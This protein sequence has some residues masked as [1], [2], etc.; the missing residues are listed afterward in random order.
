MS[1]KP[2]YRVANLEASKILSDSKDIQNFPFNVSEVIRDYTDLK[3]ATYSQALK[4]EIDIT[5]RSDEAF[6]IEMNGKYIL[7]V[8]EKKP[9]VNQK[10]SLAH[11]L[12]HFILGHEVDSCK[13]QREETEANIF[14]AQLL[15]PEHIIYELENRG[16]NITP[17]VLMACF[18]IS[19]TAADIR[20]ETLDKI[21]NF[22]KTGEEKEIN[23]G[24]VH[25]FYDFII[26]AF[27]RRNRSKD[28]SIIE[29][30]FAEI[31]KMREQLV[32]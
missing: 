1:E 3:I 4:L 28:D 18:G 11:E 24:I 25:K 26:K 13:N 9:K 31:R 30:L 8:N 20:I 16:E 14:A 17:K 12:G 32:K 5:L 29:P 6:I 27:P 22:Y 7:F 15:M 2:N 19:K 10:F 23:D 21:R